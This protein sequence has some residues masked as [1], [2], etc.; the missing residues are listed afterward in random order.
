M[1][2]L[3]PIS[4]PPP[5]PTPA[6]SPT[7]TPSLIFFLM[8]TPP[9]RS[10]PALSGLTYN[11][12]IAFVNGTNLTSGQSYTITAQANTSTRSVVFSR[13]GGVVKTDSASP[14]DF[15]T[16]P[17]VLGNH[18]FAATPWSSVGGTG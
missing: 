15:T 14:F 1:S 9:P 6:S 4:T 17:S 3:T 10:T 12:G 13:D 8:T 2:I 18:T 5:S 11:G 16:T 7:T